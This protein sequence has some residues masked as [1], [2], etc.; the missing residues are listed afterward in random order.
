MA[1]KHSWWL[2]CEERSSSL[3]HVLTVVTFHALTLSFFADT[4]LILFVVELY[5]KYLV[6]RSSFYFC[7][8]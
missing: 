7:I 4:G 2:C 5:E 6:F 8:E 1:V 3:M